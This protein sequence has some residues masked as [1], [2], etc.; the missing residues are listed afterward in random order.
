MLFVE[1]QWPTTINDEHLEQPP[2]RGNYYMV[3][4]QHK[5]ALADTT[6]ALGVHGAIGRARDKIKANSWGQ[7]SSPFWELLWMR[8]SFYDCFTICLLHLEHLGLLKVH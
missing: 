2:Q 4:E 6:S 5:K 3:C 1:S 7:E 8:A